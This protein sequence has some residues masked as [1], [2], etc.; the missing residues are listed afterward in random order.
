MSQTK[1]FTWRTS[2]EHWYL[3]VW[4]IRAQLAG[5]LLGCLWP[6]VAGF[7]SCAVKA[8]ILRSTVTKAVLGVDSLCSSTL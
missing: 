5:P 7:D 4:Y 3:C 1:C 6:L 2:G 8:W